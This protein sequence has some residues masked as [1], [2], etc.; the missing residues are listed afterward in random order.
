VVKEDQ[1][2]G[3]DSTGEGASVRFPPPF[4]AL[5]ALA[6][7]ALFEWAV[8]PL[9]TPLSG[10]ARFG[11][12]G[13]LVAGG[14]ALLLAAGSLFRETGQDPKPWKSSPEI[15]ASG[16]YRRTRNPMYLGMGIMQAGL[17]V[18]FACMWIVALVPVTWIVIYWT[19]IRHE[20]AYL[21]DKF[22]ESY[23]EYKASVRRWV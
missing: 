17:G 20:E 4:V 18:L 15:I 8:G 23:L 16:I 19:A 1:S 11:V 21:T 12:G 22:G 2:E 6:I 13:L 7:G 10:G 5:L 14:I 9:A 3:E